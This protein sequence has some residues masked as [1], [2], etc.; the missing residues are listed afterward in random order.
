M[1]SEYPNSLSIS[2]DKS[3]GSRKSILTFLLITHTILT[4]KLGSLSAP[5][6]RPLQRKRVRLRA[7]HKTR[8]IFLSLGGMI[9]EERNNAFE[10]SMRGRWDRSTREYLSRNYSML[11]DVKR[12][13]AAG[14][15]HP[16]SKK[17]HHEIKEY[18]P[19][20]FR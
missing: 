8:S 18:F 6:R 7:T 15:F 16:R 3:V 2:K 17:A 5:N 1:A 11:A 19:N 10:I 20:V 13:M 14:L 12:E 9:I 4:I